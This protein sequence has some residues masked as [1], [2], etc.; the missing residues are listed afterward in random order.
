LTTAAAASF[1]PFEDR[2]REVAVFFIFKFSPLFVTQ[3]QTDKKDK[4]FYDVL[5]SSE[6]LDLFAFHDFFRKNF[7]TGCAILVTICRKKD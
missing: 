1:R 7:Q 6:T 2:N 4:R 5:A 3:A